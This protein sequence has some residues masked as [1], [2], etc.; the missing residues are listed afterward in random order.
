MTNAG[1]TIQV[2][3]LLGNYPNTRALKQGAV[4]SPRLRFDF[5]E[6]DLP[7]NAFKAVVRGEF[8]VAELA[9]VTYLQALA[10]GK[11]LT[12]LPAVVMAIPPHPCLACNARAGRLRPADLHGR[13]VG[14]R[15][16]SV[17]TVAWVRGI[18]ANDYGVDLDRVQWVA[19]EDPHVPECIE[20]PNVTRAP[21]GKSLV[22]MLRAGELDA[23]V[24][25]VSDQADGVLQPV[26]P[27]PELALAGWRKR[28][29]VRPMN[30]VVTLHRGLARARP[31]VAEEVMRLLKESAADAPAMPGADSIVFGVE[32]MRPALELIVRYAFQQG[33][34]PR[35]FAV[36]ELF[37]G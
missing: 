1:G 28:H 30:H 32:A 25:S 10:H 3:A 33:L 27:D 8:D 9:I 22:G 14:I 7:Q 37:D 35:P 19:F 6:V 2:R 15:A 16:H 4:S 17:T 5:H 23:G 12:L 34:I 20:P 21:A 24:V 31:W 36:D 26:I 11:P 18:L 29:G 13:R